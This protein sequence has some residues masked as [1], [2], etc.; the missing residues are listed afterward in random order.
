MSS[1]GTGVSIGEI[2]YV[3]VLFFYVESLE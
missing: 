3:L 1:I 2:S